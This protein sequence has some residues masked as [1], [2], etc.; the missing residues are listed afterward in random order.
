MAKVVVT[1]QVQDAA[2]WEAGFRTHG[3]LFRTMKVQ[4]AMHYAINGNEI[5]VFAETEDVNA[6]L[7]VLQSQATAEAM[8]HDGVKRETVR[9]FVLDKEMKVPAGSATGA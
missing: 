1:A 6:Y 2:K 7:R 3:D 8:A 9:S 5:A 4:G